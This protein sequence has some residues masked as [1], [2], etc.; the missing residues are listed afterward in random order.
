MAQIGQPAPDFTLPGVDG[1]TYTL[2]DLV[3]SHGAV[4]VVFS[5]NHCPYVRAWEGR[6]IEIQRDY[7]DKDVVL[8][9]VNPND[10]TRYPDDSFDQMKARAQEDFNFL[11]LRDESQSAAR[12]FGGERT[13]H[14]FLLDGA[15]IV[16]YVGAIDDN[17][18]D[19]EAVKHTF[20]RDALD[21]VLNGQ[22]PA[23][24]ETPAVGC[25][26]KWITPVQ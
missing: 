19:P 6:M 8:V 13:P 15:G 10:E 11:Y 26:I 12:D 17:H 24:A 3:R 21:A 2:S 9:A 25:T 16:R 18:D 20:L 23:V 22:A 5:C 7:Q 14:V 1:H 4:A